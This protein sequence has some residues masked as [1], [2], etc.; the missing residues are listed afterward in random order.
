MSD[1]M[2]R[3]RELDY[4]VVQVLKKA[5]RHPVLFKTLNRA[6]AREVD[7][8]RTSGVVSVLEKLV[9]DGLVL[10]LKNDEYFWMQNLD[11]LARK[12]CD[13]LEL[14]HARYPFE[15]GIRTGDIKKEFSEARTQNAR[16]NID[17]RLFETV[18]SA[19]MEDGLVVEAALGVRL[20]KFIP[21][22]QNDPEIETLEKRIL[23]IVS[24]GRSRRIGI[25]ALSHQIGADERKTKAIV[26]E[27]VKGGRLVRIE[28]NR[29]LAPE[30]LERMKQTLA[31]AFETK[32]KLR[33]GEIVA[34]IG[35]S[36]IASEAAFLA[37]T[38][39]LVASTW[40]A[41]LS[42]RRSALTSSTLRS[43]WEVRGPSAS[44]PA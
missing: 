14:F 16:K 5:K 18:I 7:T 42:L 41:P 12:L 34:L 35:E 29:Y 21:Q 22:S 33:I 17:P 4:A 10:R 13:I 44:P 24:A 40:P 19:C 1:S 20:S 31:A 32:S 39:L 3:N 23:E 15:P 8:H 30:G 36:R 6:V 37:C 9:N 11:H 27:M 43:A 26:S 38:G 2:D 25:E 28:D